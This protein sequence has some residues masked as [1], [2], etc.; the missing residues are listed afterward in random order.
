MSSERPLAGGY[1]RKLYRLMEPLHRRRAGF[2]VVLLAIAMLLEVLGIGFVIPALVV[3]TTPDIGAKYPAI[4][5]LLAAL[6]HPTQAELVVMGMGSLVIIYAVKSGF[7]VYVSWFQSRFVF[8]LFSNLAQ[9]LFANYLRMPYEFFLVRN[10]AP[11]MRN[12]TTEL[13]YFS[14][15]AQS[16]MMFFTECV[17]MSGIIVLLVVIEPIGTAVVCLFVGSAAW[18]FQRAIRTRLMRWGTLR[19]HHDGLRIQH[20]QQGIGSVKDIKVL[21][22]EE[23]FLQKFRTHNYGF[24]GVLQ[25]QYFTQQLPRLWLEL[26]AV[27]GLAAVVFLMIA[28]GTPLSSVLPTIGLFGAAAFRLIP[29]VN[30]AMVALQGTRFGRP[31]IEL[32]YQE[33]IEN[34]APPAVPSGIPM[35]F[36]QS[37]E[38][39]NLSFSYTGADRLALDGVS[40]S[41]PHGAC[42]GFIGG[43]GAGKSSLIDLL[44]GVLTPSSGRIAVDGVDIQSNLRGWQG[45]IGYVPQSI[46][47]TDD[48]LKRNVAF[49]LSD[50]QLDEVAVWRALRY[51]QLDQFIRDL[52]D[53][54]ETM[55]GERGVRLSGG[56]RQRIAIAR[57]L[58][59]DPDVLVLDEATSALD[60]ATESGVMEAVRAMQGTKTILIVA[61]RLTTVANCDILVL[62]EKG[63][64]KQVARSLA[65]IKQAGMTEPVP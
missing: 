7:L 61:H 35:P 58:Y 20:I 13:N 65:E 40:L 19:Q 23:D 36:R 63:R 60:N 25:R 55:V 38:F 2:L 5:P 41:I 45:H 4:A 57:A 1:A 16:T 17:I 8:G 59:H 9:R 46:F 54:L 21:G 22:R 56:Q 42:V 3:I 12:L 31:G 18:I 24:T 51:A 28:R 6:G 26:L 39:E 32:L 62:L 30:R 64:I 44:M 47:L 52:P 10:S 43:S 53:G 34:A 49:G 50:A 27:M 33:L 37:V 48:T 29:S 11:L 15:A 14:S